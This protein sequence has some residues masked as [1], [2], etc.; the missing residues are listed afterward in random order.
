MRDASGYPGMKVLEFAFYSAEPS[1]YAPHNH[2]RNAVCYIGT[3]DNVTARQWF[4]ETDA[5]TLQY[6]SS[7]MALNQQEGQ[8]WGMIRTAMSSVCDMCILQLQDCL[9]LGSEARMNSPG[10][11]TDANWT[12]R[13]QPGYDRPELVEKLRELTR[14]YGRLGNQIASNSEEDPQLDHKN[15][16]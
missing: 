7:Y 14:R 12:W 6:A 9:E 8:V 2:I 15:G 3:H 16:E 10:L 11:L 1:D 5:V 13:V 4:E